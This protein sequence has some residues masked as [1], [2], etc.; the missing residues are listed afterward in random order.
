M[1]RKTADFLGKQLK[2]DEVDILKD[3]LSFA[4][5]KTNPAVNYEEAVELNK[6]LKLIQAD[7]QFMRSGQVDQWKEKMS[8][9][10]IERFDKWT[11]ENLKN[12]DLRF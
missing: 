3:H 12:T 7:G 1:I 11:V 9:E 5:M 8:G 4:S 6:K 2:S 10:V